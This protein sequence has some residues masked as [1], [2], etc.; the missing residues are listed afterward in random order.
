MNFKQVSLLTAVLCLPEAAA[1][2]QSQQSIAN[3]PPPSTSSAY[4]SASDIIPATRGGTPGQGG[5]STYGL[6]YNGANLS[7]N[8][9]FVGTNTFMGNL[10][11][12]T[13]ASGSYA[14][15]V[16]QAGARQA[17]FGSTGANGSY[18]IVDNAAGGNNAGIQLFDA[19]NQKWFIGK[20]TDNSFTLQD[21][22]GSITFLN[23]ATGANLTLGPA[24]NVY[25]S[26]AGTLSIGS[27]TT[28]YALSAVQ[29][30]STQAYFGSTG[31]NQANVTINNAA[32]TQ[33]SQLNFQSGGVDK[34]HLFF[35]NAGSGNFRM[36]DAVNNSSILNYDLSTR[37]TTLGNSQ[38]FS[39]LSNGQV[40]ESMDGSS[41]APLVINNIAAG[42]TSY[43]SEVF[44]RQGSQ[45]GSI[46]VTSSATAYNTSSDSRI[47]TSI[48]ALPPV[49]SA[50][51]IIDQLQPSTYNFIS[52]YDPGQSVGVGFIAQQLNSIIPLAVTPGDTS[53]VAYAP[54]SSTF[55][56]WQVDLSKLVPYIVADLQ[57]VHRQILP[58]ASG[59]SCQAGTVN[60]TTFTVT[61]GVVTHC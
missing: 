14:L 45:V 10:G 3:L 20:A 53:N 2:A 24:Q 51:N 61:S 56:L 12:G 19:G 54:K 25:L 52:T 34:F 40:T 29:A 43:A 38:A 35:Y 26:Q 18:V 4:L 17:Y 42:S 47:K 22:V 46:S 31:A 28:S 59:V 13:A 5:G 39:I 16:V 50:G 1:Y 32:G 60:L 49:N 27:Y 9:I 57:W 33:N 15:D 55:K 11:V 58:L 30:G 37:S 6:L 48:A 44:D 7:T 41:T 36:Q 21:N 8:N 23:A